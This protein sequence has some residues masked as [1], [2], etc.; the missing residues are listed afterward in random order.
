MG[1]MKQSKD[2]EYVEFDRYI[3]NKMTKKDIKQIIEHCDIALDRYY[4]S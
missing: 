1:F 2:L 4:N 3:W